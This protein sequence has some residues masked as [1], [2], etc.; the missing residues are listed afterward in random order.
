[1]SEKQKYE[2]WLKKEIEENDLLEISFT[3]SEEIT[4]KEDLYRAIN[5]FIKK[6]NST[7]PR[8]EVTFL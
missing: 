2:N 7:E 1:M 8:F 4:D 5:E 3:V 6:T